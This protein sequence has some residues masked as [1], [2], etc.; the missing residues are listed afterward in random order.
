V[1]RTIQRVLKD[2]NPGRFMKN[3]TLL[4]VGQ[5]SVAARWFGL[6][7]IAVLLPLAVSL[8]AQ[9]PTI[10][11]T[12]VTTLGGGP[13]Y[14]N[15]GHSFGS[16]NSV[17][18]TLYS[19]FHTPSGL[20]YDSFQGYLYVADRDNNAIRLIDPSPN[21]SEIFTFAPDPPYVPANLISQPVGV[22]V[23][24]LSDVFV[25]NRG[26]G[27]NG[28][29]V[30][31][32]YLGNLIATNMSKLT[33]AS[34]I[35]LDTIGD[36]YV[37]ASN[38][39]FKITPAGV[40]NVV[41]TITKAGTFL[42]GIVVKRSGPSAGWLA[43]CDSG[44]NGIYLINPTSGAVTTNAGFNGAGDGTGNRNQ[45]V[46]NASARFFQPS[47][48]AEAGDGSLI[49][50]DFGNHRVK[51]VTVAGLTTNLYG[52]AS[53]YWWTGTTPTGGTALKGWSDGAVWE[54]DGGPGF[55]NVQARMP[56]GVAIGPD[57]TIYTTEDYYHIIRDVTGAN[58]KPP[59]PP[60]PAAPT[61]L[62]VTTNFG[63]VTLTW[64]TVPNATDYNVERAPSSGGPYTIIATNITA[65]TF[66]D[67]SVVNGN[68]YYYVVSASNTG[69]ESTNSA[70][71]STTPPLPPVPDPQIGW[72]TFPPTSTP[73]PYTSVFNVGSPSGV[74]FNNDVPIVIIGAAGSK[75]LYTYLNTPTVTNVPDPTF[76]SVS[77]PVGYVDGLPFSTVTNLTVAQ[78][79]P[80]LAI[81][82]IGE[83]SG[84]PNSAV[85]S[86]LFQFIVGNPQVNGTDAAQFTVSSITTGAQMYYTTDG[87]VPSPTNVSAIGPITNG[88]M[89]SLQFPAST[90]L[91]QFQIAGFKANYQPSVI[92]T[93]TF[94][95]SNYVANTISFG[96]A[97]GEASSAFVG[98][99]G[100]T[101][102][103][104]VTLTMLPGTPVYSLQ[105][106]VSVSSTGVGVTNPAPAA[107]PFNFQ[108]ML[109]LP[110][111][112]TNVPGTVYFAIP[113]W[114]FAAN[115]TTSL[116]P[117]DYVTNSAGQVFVNLLVSN[118]N[119]LA[120]GWLERYG[121]TNLY[122]TTVQDLIQYSL[123]HDDL[124]PNS[125]QPNGVIAGGYS[126][127]ISSGAT[128]GQQYQI[129]VGQAS[130]TDDGIGTPGSA[131]IIVAPSGTNS[132]SLG[133]GTLNAIKNVTIG[134]IPYLVG[135]VYPFRWFNAGD[136][137]SSNLTKYGSAD[138]EQVFQ[139]AVYSWNMPPPGSD[140]FDAMDSAGGIGFQ[141]LDSTTLFYGY[142]TNA[143]ITNTAVLLGGDFTNIN[144]MAFG[145]GRLDV[146]DVYVTFLR[147]EFT[148]NLLW[149]E[150]VWTNGV[151]VATANYAPAIEPAL[152]KQLSSGG[153]K[154]QPAFNSSLSPVSITNTPSVNFTAGDYQATPGQQ[155]SIPV[156]A[157]VFGA[158]PLSVLMLNISVVPLDGSPALTTPVLFTLNSPFNNLNN[159]NPGAAGLQD[160][161][162]NGNYSVALLPKQFPIPQN[163]GVTGNAVIG[164]LT[165][166]I[167]AN[168]TSLSAYAVHFDHASASPSGL[169]SFP[170]HTLTGL[171]TLSSRTNSTYNDGI[172][173]SWRLRY[174]GTIYNL[175]S[176]SNAC[177]SG[178]GINNWGK[179]V[180]GVDPNTPNDFPSLNPNT[181][182][183]SGAAMSIYW[184]TVSGKQYAILSSASLFPGNWIT[185]AIL[186]GT[187]TD[188]EFDDNST[189]TVKFYRVL[190]LP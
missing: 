59:L 40:S 163:L 145:D 146:A 180:A 179:Y 128:N 114:M 167:P 1:N 33:N 61:I 123:A 164:T 125:Q 106:D 92:V 93:N 58:I 15:P 54:P 39:V 172:S 156:T 129:Q 139:S 182:P 22:A 62:T 65:T 121:R 88:T 183:P 117:E 66:T 91:L 96:F 50:S 134:S 9:T 188:M 7:A 78:I 178:D 51:V 48:I 10:T 100:Q 5:E 83:Q 4:R 20:A 38:T 176:V 143:Y 81:K 52:V 67:T 119:Q 37:T 35:A 89:L 120:V 87:S 165:I 86:A 135:D 159:Y 111:T 131:V 19:Q 136:F 69:G 26:N 85:V 116:P 99:S 32:D 77:A 64:S 174:F 122:N 46:F 169:I 101:F 162:G 138:A 105:F 148:N 2:N 23:D 28:T 84:H 104:P 30:E 97:S 127:K 71:V 53:N 130:A 181:P 142:Y 155:I 95:A 68:T 76:A 57:G 72:V 177:P 60:P 109:M 190:I 108:S 115:E 36:I 16:S 27:A 90:N 8:K 160:S 3:A 133:A 157:S 25:L 31:F 47:G 24:A 43:V 140:F 144:Q 173:D 154:V 18:G 153:G 132:A 150:R 151:R 149:F 118:G 41:V 107:G 44:R 55:G 147:S 103:A 186:T 70:E 124:F 166:T 82:A 13:Q 11:E 113:P 74:T 112:E 34:G 184:P 170:K 94:Y 158:Y 14:Y 21:P 45:G 17:Y 102:Y 12:T 161:F 63:Q 42:Q 29:V 56:F 6:L 110:G 175:L 79:L 126:F 168:A 137:G 185:N 98:A 189:G 152:Q 73:F 187:G 75:T 171:I 49:V 141:D 80:N